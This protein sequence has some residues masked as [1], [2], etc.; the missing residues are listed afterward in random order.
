M[1]SRRTA[2]PVLI[3][4]GLAAAWSLPAAA[5]ASA[6][7]GALLGVRSRLSGGSGVALTFD[8]GPHPDGTPAASSVLAGKW[9]LLYIGDGRCNDACRTALVFGRQERGRQPRNRFVYPQRFR[10]GRFSSRR[11]SVRP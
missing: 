11:R 1:G 2:A 10:P 5:K 7:F 8:D 3:A 6:G 4:A 9:T